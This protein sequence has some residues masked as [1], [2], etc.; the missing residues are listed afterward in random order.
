M[1]R[2]LKKLREHRASFILLFLLGADFAFIMFHVIIAK[3]YCLCNVVGIFTY[4]KIYNLIKLLG[5]TVL[6]VY[7]LR[8]TRCSSYISWILVFTYFLL[9]DALLLHQKIGNY[10]YAFFDS[11]SES[12]SLRPR[13]FELAVLAT[14][15]I[16]LLAVIARGYSRGPK[17]FRKI[18]EDMLLFL[19][20]L[21]LLGLIVDLATAIKLGP[22][23]VFVLGF[24]EDGGELVVD[25]LILWYVFLLALHNGRFEVFLHDRLSQPQ[26]Q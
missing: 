6:F 15:G 9:D 24:V 8:S 2:Y 18:S 12:L 10:F 17:V 22:T 4:V 5:I 7:V 26:M 16:T 3:Y 21:V 19:V 13:F 20:A 25:S 1:I 23:I 14:V 11:H